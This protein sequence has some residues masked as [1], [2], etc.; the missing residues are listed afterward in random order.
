VLKVFVVKVSAGAKSDS[1]AEEEQWIRVRTVAPRE[2][3][4]ANAAVCSLI[5][6]YFKVPK[7]AVCILRGESSTQKLIEVE[8]PD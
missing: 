2:K 4:K 1:V 6:K 7:S 5:A 3:G 8:L